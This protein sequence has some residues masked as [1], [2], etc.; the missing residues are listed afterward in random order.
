RK[1]VALG[2]RASRN[3]P[4]PLMPRWSRRRPGGLAHACQ[5]IDRPAHLRALR[6]L[7]IVPGDL[8]VPFVPAAPDLTRL[9]LAAGG[10]WPTGPGGPRE[11]RRSVLATAAP[12]ETLRELAQSPRSLSGRRLA[13]LP[14][15]RARPRPARRATDR[16]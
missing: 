5:R 6:R 1:R 2:K 12:R 14:T 13:G 3:A 10:R 16:R 8:D 11:Q 15:R 7:R 4:P 9:G